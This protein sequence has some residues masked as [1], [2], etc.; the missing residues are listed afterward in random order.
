MRIFLLFI[1]ISVST[2]L[3]AQTEEQRSV[4]PVKTV[5]IYPN[6]ATDFLTL[7]FE[8]PIAQNVRLEFFSIIGAPIKVEREII[9]ETEIRVYVKE[10]A[11][12][13]YVVSIQDAQS[14][15]RTIHKFLKK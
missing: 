14:N 10:L 9:D 6:P 3:L 11:A 7:K 15:S 12:G 2:Q 4:D 8:S 13:Y 1:L 5:Q